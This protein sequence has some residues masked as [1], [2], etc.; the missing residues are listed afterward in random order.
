[1]QRHSY[2][3]GFTSH[4]VFDIMLSMLDAEECTHFGG[5]REYDY[6]W[7]IGVDVW[8]RITSN[9]GFNNI[10]LVY[11][12]YSVEPIYKIFGIEVT[13]SKKNKRNTIILRKKKEIGKLE[14]D[15]ITINEKLTAAEASIGDL[16]AENITISGEIA[17][18][19]ASIKDLAQSGI[20]KD[21][22]RRNEMPFGEQYYFDYSSII[23]KESNRVI[24][25]IK[26]VIFNDPATIV[27]WEDGS[28]T[29]VKCQDG[30]IYDPEKGLAMAISKKAL[31]NQGNYC[32]VFKKWLPEEEK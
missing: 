22:V 16:E 11:T 6:E 26:K 9:N 24:P 1:M 28:K 8:T 18:N 30:D 14:A 2:L 5:I 15:N 21:L 4:A 3:D 27:F 17:A 19:K 32:E 7:V 13:I 10:S 23:F 20:I 12:N 25:S 29:V 31:G